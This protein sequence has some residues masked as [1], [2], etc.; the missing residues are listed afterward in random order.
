MSQPSAFDRD[1]LLS[2]GYGEMFGQGNAR[3][4]VGNMLMID[5]ITHIS[6]TSG[7]YNKGEITAELD[8]TPDLWF[9]DCHFPN[10]PVMPGCLGLDLSLIHI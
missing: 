7:A 1:A 2:C 5:R 3:L 4:P 6:A 9:F 10:D 8:I